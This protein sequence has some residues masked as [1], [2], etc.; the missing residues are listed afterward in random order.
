MHTCTGWSTLF[1]MYIVAFQT[2]F[3]S[4]ITCF[5]PAADQQLFIVMAVFAKHFHEGV[6]IAFRFLELLQEGPKH[7]LGR[8][9]SCDCT[10]SPKGESVTVQ[11]SPKRMVF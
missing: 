1:L 4:H 5:Q 10:E 7:M 8:A 2:E 3:R 9:V 6:S 11:G